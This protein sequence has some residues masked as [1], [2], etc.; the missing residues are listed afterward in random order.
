MSEREATEM[1]RHVE[2][3]RC[4]SDSEEDG[5]PIAN[6]VQEQDKDSDVWVPTTDTQAMLAAAEKKAIEDE[7]IFADVKAIPEGQEAVGV[8]AGV[9]IARDFEKDLG[10]FIG[11]VKHVRAQRKRHVYHVQYEDGDSE[12]FDLEEYQFAY[13]V[14]KA[15]DAG[16]FRRDDNEG[17]NDD[18]ISNDGTE[19]EW[20][21]T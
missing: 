10:V 20:N 16:K 1:S 18:R 4:S 5:V 3:L 17:E 11:E 15:L 6:T 2:V 19:D 8:A 9:G 12:D 13:E 14:R 21:D 7:A